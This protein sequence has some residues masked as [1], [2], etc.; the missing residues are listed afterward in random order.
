MGQAGRLL[1]VLRSV[2]GKGAEQVAGQI[3]L[4]NRLL[5]L[6]KESTAYP[7]VEGDVV[8]DPGRLLIHLV[9]PSRDL[10]A[11]QPPAR[12]VIPLRSSVLLVNGHRD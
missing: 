3:G 5:A 8:V 10:S 7:V 1:S 2:P 12:P 4:A 9:K 6:L 11:D